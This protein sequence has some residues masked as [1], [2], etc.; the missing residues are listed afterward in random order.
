MLLRHYTRWSVLGLVGWV[1]VSA[2]AQENP[3]LKTM[4]VTATRD[5]TALEELTS[6]NTLISREDIEA[7]GGRT[8]T[9]VLSRQAG[10]M[11]SSNGGLG[12]S[13]NMYIRGTDSR[14]VLLLIDG[15]RYGSATTGQPNWDTI[16]LEMVD[17]IEVLKGPASALYGSDAVGGVVHI[18]T[19][20]AEKG[21]TPYGS[22]TVGSYGHSEWAAG[23]RGGDETWSYALGAQTQTETGF[24]ATN[25][26][27]GSS[28]NPDDDGFDQNSLNA[29]LG[30]RLSRHV[31]LKASVLQSRGSTEYDNRATSD[32]DRID[33]D[34][35]VQQIGVDVQV[36][37][38]WKTEVQLASSSD[39]STTI[40]S[41][42]TYFNTAK[43]QLQWL[44]H[45]QTA[46]GVAEAGAET[47]RE[48]VDST[49][50]Y[51]VTDRTIASAFVGL[52]GSAQAHSW[53]VNARQ[54]RNSQFGT[55]NTQVAGYGYRFNSEW[56][57]HVSYGTSFKAPTFNQLYFPGFGNAALVP[58]K[59]T[60]QEA[61]LTYDWG[62][63]SLTWTYYY[64]RISDYIGSNASFVSIN[65]PAARMEG[66]TVALDGES[67]DWAWHAAV[68][69][70]DARNEQNGL[71]LARR[72]T[73]QLTA[74]VSR[75][76]GLWRMGASVLAANESYDDAANTKTLGGYGVVD[77]FASYRVRKDWSLEGRL[78]NVGDK[79]YQTALGY[80]QPGRSLYL[81]LR[82]LP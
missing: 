61:A 64:N 63:S 71:Y 23:L 72:P 56:R 55:A 16:P 20:K 68:D 60:N 45:V 1:C 76:L 52:H 62:R 75:K 42:T 5:A 2:T 51:A 50:N 40:N 7:S 78:N 57:S 67:D 44:N 53:Q 25:R 41:S 6:D 81:T 79:F 34:T 13:S 19:R 28:Y 43:E 29:S 26:R 21:F 3:Q 9:E 47:S 80:N 4:V 82:Y 37:E 18:F 74:N 39:K 10:I 11:M 32:D 49:T 8:L 22:V 24:S 15:V 66:N 73:S 48:M 33:F 17:H 30:Y 59:G 65:T 35:R 38:R 70:V 36:T 46:W 12:K 31:Q 69:F 27:V 58:E 14:H 54:D 77:L